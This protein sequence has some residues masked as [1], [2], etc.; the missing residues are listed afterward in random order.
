[1]TDLDTGL[2]EEHEPIPA[3][4]SAAPANLRSAAITGTLWTLVQQWGSHIISTAVFVALGRLVRPEAF[5]LIA[6]AAVFVGFL[7]IVVRHGFADAIIQR[8]ELGE[9]QLQSAFA[10]VLV[11]ATSLTLLLVLSAGTIGDL[12]GEPAVA[13]VLRWMS[14]ALVF[15]ALASVPSAVLRRQLEFRSL[16]LRTLIAVVVGGVAGISVALAGG[17]VWALVVQL[18]GESAA[19]VVVLWAVARWRPSARVS[20]REVRAVLAFGAAVT[21]ANYLGFL[22]RHLDDLLIG[23]FLGATALGY[24]AVGYR[25][26][27]VMN[28]VL[29]QA[30]SAVAFPVLSRMQDDRPRMVRS[31]LQSTRVTSIV[32]MPAFVGMAVLAPELITFLFGPRWEASV[33]VMQILALIGIQRSC[34]HLNGMALVAV[35]KPQW[36]LAFMAVSVGATA[37]GFFVA[38][39]WFGIV[40]VAASLVITNYLVT[41][42]SLVLLRRAIGL[43]PATYLRQFVTPVLASATMAGSLQ[44]FRLLVGDALPTAA[45]LAGGVVLGVV[46]YA[47]AV[48]VLDR[49]AFAEVVALAKEP[50]AKVSG[51]TRRPQE[52]RTT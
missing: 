7:Q 6:L 22:R 33:P 44:M 5:G 19:G 14:L 45:L 31:L 13:P 30:F 21:A 34:T 32:A 1:M 40:G 36:N 52:G 48:R 4:R 47:A 43:S 38:I 17:G 15:T 50:L 29:L 8:K 46:I 2:D 39:Q 18:L 10:A 28:V 12:L 24:Y 9:E 16:A 27:T 3:R 37:I 11:L 26:L 23:A 49:R 25:V 42:L 51:A 35:G 20:L 41:P